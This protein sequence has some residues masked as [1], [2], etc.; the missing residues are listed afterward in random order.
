MFLS[1]AG[2]RLNAVSITSNGGLFTYIKID[3][4]WAAKLLVY[5]GLDWFIDMDVSTGTI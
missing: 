3:T 1:L 5:L 2:A 4:A